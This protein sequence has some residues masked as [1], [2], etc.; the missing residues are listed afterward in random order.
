MRMVSGA[1]SVGAVVSSSEA[2]SVEVSVLTLA[3]FAD[4]AIQL[5]VPVELLPGQSASCKCG[6]AWEISLSAE[7]DAD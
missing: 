2:V 3:R 1:S 4:E 5:E 7:V 6:T